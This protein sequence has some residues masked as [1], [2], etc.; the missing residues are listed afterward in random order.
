MN[1]H[2][3]VLAIMEWLRVTTDR[4][5]GERA[6]PLYVV[7]CG[8]IWSAGSN[9]IPVKL[10]HGSLAAMPLQTLISAYSNARHMY[11]WEVNLSANYMFT[12]S[13]IKMK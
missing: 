13:V 6:G 2:L 5:I 11:I 9:G 7:I 12:F 8:C 3:C 1:S 10:I 4:K